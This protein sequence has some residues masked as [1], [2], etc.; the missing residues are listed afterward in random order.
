MNVLI[1]EN[2]RLK[3][4]N[5]QLR[6][7]NSC[8][9]EQ[10]GRSGKEFNLEKFKMMINFSD[11]TLAYLTTMLSKPYLGLLALQSTNLFIQI[12]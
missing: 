3:E 4:I 2:Q 12:L 9:I 8:L 11:F 1:E 5:S 7:E 6:Y 10:V